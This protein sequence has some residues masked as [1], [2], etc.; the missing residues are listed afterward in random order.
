MTRQ[1]LCGFGMPFRCACSSC[2][3]SVPPPS[4]RGACTRPD[5][6]NLFPFHHQVSYPLFLCRCRRKK[7]LSKRNAKGETRKGGFLK[8]APF[9]SRKNFSATGAKHWVVLCRGDHW[10]PAHSANAPKAPRQ[11]FSRTQVPVTSTAGKG[12]CEAPCGAPYSRAE[13]A[14]TI[15]RTRGSGS[16]SDSAQTHD[17]PH[18]PHIPAAE[19]RDGD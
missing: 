4:R 8:K 7:K 9:K 2:R 18:I 5:V 17:I 3:L 1:V 16:G 13:N 19:K 11:L 10:S 15:A 14:P 12:H 6:K